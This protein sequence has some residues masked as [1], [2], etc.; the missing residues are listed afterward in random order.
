MNI[1]L[2]VFHRSL[3]LY[4]EMQCLSVAPSEHETGAFFICNI[5]ICITLGSMR[6]LLFLLLHH[7]FRWSHVKCS[8]SCWHHSSTTHTG[9]RKSHVGKSLSSQCCQVF[10]I[11][12]TMHPPL[13]TTTTLRTNRCIILYEVTNL[14]LLQKR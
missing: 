13:V 1:I 10:R 14:R 8:Q 3:I 4:C 7:S 12:L 9:T 6:S 11:K 5:Y 2:L